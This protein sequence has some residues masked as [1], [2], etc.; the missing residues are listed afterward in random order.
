[1]TNPLRTETSHDL[2]LLLARL[3]IGV[4]FLLA[5][6]GKVRSGVTD[7]V[8]ANANRLPDFLPRP[9]GET[10]LYAVPF[11]EILVGTLAILGLLGR[12]T[13]LVMAAMLISFM[14]GVTGIKG[15]SGPFHY[16]LVFLG[17]SLLL[18]LTGPGRIS[19]DRFWRRDAGP[20]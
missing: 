20:R 1:M 17:L 4:F 8:H 11:L 2:G 19:A 9:I 16:N 12:T 10:Y 15:S 6:I 13:G 5:G 18:F 7:F 3:P 14:I